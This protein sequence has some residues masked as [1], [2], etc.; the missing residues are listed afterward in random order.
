MTL[1][2]SYPD[3]IVPLLM[4]CLETVTACLSDCDNAPARV[5]DG[6]GRG[7]DMRASVFFPSPRLINPSISMP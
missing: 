3:M 5:I 1:A 4:S 6:S 7:P 2:L